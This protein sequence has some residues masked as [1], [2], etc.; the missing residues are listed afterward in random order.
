MLSDSL[1][2]DSARV[3]SDTVSVAPK[4]KKEQIVDD[5]IFYSAV[6]SMS[7]L[8]VDQRV[9]LWGSG[10]VEYQDIELT[11]EH[12]DSD[13]EK[14]EVASFGSFDTSGVYFGSPHFKKG[15]EVFDADSMNYNIHSGKGI[16]YNVKT[17][18]GEGYLHSDLTKRDSQGHVHMKGGKYTTCDAEHPHFYME[19]TKAIAIPDDKIITG[20]AYLVVEDV[21]IPFLGIPFG[22]F[23]STQ[24]RSAGV[25]IPTYGEETTRGFYLQNGGWYQPIGQYVDVRL[26]GDIYTK[27]SWALNLSSTY[28]VNY[29]FSGSTQIDYAANRDNSDSSFAENES[30]RWMWSHSQDSKANPN[31]SFS[32][33]V[34][35]SSTQYDSYNSY[36]Y[37]EVVQQ[38]KSSS[39]SFSKSWP[40]TPFNLAISANATQNTSDS[41]LSM[42][43][44]TGSFNASTIYPFRKE[45]ATGSLRW[46][47][48]IGFSYSSSFANDIEIKD[49]MLFDHSTW[50]ELNYGFQHSIPLVINLKTDKIKMLTISP[51]LSYK[52]VMNSWHIKKYT[53]YNGSEIEIATDTIREVT[54]AHAINPSISVGLTPK[55]TGMYLNTRPNPNIIAIRHVMTPK[56]S[57]SYTPNMSMINP[58]YYDTLYYMQDGELETYSYSYYDQ[59]LYGAPSSAGQSGSLSL[60]ISNT[61]DMKM[62]PKNDTANGGE[63]Q[64]VSLLKSFNLSTSY[65]P[66]AEEYKWS[67]VS[68]N[69][70]TALFKDKLNLNVTS[71]FSPYDYTVDTSSSGTISTSTINNFYYE[72]GKG[73]LRFTSMNLSAGL[74]LK[75]KASTGGDGKPMSEEDEFDNSR[76]PFNNNNDFEAG[77]TSGEYVDF[78]VPWSLRVNYTWSLSRPY[79]KEDQTVTNTVNLSG[80]F[81]LT[82]KW[83]I[84]FNTGYDIEEREVTITNINVH[85]DLHCWEMQ[86]TITP[87]G[88]RQ[89]Y[90]F[91]IN[92]KA[93]M[94]RD[95]L[96]H[97]VNKS[98]YD[99]L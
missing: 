38:Q 39:I 87:F 74:S 84:G 94:L 37:N 10:K 88:T 60:S 24:R 17:E 3:K 5:P 51:S 78:S 50:E 85:R 79:A 40:G 63:P 93:S 15:E 20:P 1:K 90:S 68:L 12:I 42:S 62:A 44:P 83:K 49:S 23:P 65:N 25:I 55:V 36:D 57:F 80:D 6:D 92:A 56:A 2:F 82:P 70:G 96:K 47:E 4:E 22:F 35:F 59:N 14:Q 73:L 41:T 99:N 43:L 7:I 26:M 19:L 72:S 18:Q 98:W 54:Y 61:L 45:N 77:F 13:M 33:S 67:T 31:Q 11:S 30:F 86:F 69:T 34:N 46:Y 21:P 53:E 64:K 97:E 76:D 16:I 91:T 32:A 66:F 52:G 89:N 81:S 48:N 95:A 58:N 27:G 28:R 71:K 8:V 75:S 9:L 29:K